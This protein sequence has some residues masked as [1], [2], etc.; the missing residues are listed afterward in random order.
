MNI[1]TIVSNAS[2]MTSRAGVVLKKASPEILTGIG[3]VGV[4]AGTVLACKATLKADEVLDEHQNMI[5]RIHN[6]ADVSEEYAETNQKRDT[7]VA[8]GHTA[9]NF[10]KLY[11]PSAI[12]IGGGIGCII[13]GHAVLYRRNLACVAAYTAVTDAFEKYRNRVIEEYGEKKDY[14]YRFG[15][16]EVGEQKIGKDPDTGK[17]IKDTIIERWGQDMSQF[18]RAFDELNDNYSRVPEYN[19][20]FL[21]SRQAEANRILKKRG[22]IFLNE[23]YD[24]LGIPRSQ[25]GTVVGWILKDGEEPHVD[26]GLYDLSDGD[27][28]RFINGYES[29]VWLDFNVDGIIYDLI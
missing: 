23:V 22:H 20:L 21:K 8:Y 16:H 7:A 11:A 18:A 9:L 15:I 19:L 2:R 29:A 24:L 28:R 27:K 17:P 26:F 6:A 12:L 1:N 4:L 25:I 5:D 3:I 13:G 14:D 10:A